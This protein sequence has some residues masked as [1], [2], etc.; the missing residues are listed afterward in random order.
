MAS[1]RTCCRVSNIIIFTNNYN[2][3]K[4]KNPS[5]E[6]ASKTCSATLWGLHFS[7]PG[8]SIAPFSKALVLSNLLR[9]VDSIRKLCLAGPNYL[10]IFPFGLVAGVT[11]KVPLS[12]VLISLDY[13]PW[14]F[15]ARRNSRDYVSQPTLCTM[16]QGTVRVF[17]N[18][19]KGPKS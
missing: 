11:G 5:N 15:Q 7:C 17:S 12:Y 6:H 13:R 8:F 1:P 4:K 18:Q 2:A 19:A 9:A 3:K 14:N 16:G 10:L